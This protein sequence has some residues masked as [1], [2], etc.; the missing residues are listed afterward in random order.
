[1]RIEYRSGTIGVNAN[2]DETTAEI[3]AVQDRYSLGKDFQLPTYD[4]IVDAIDSL[5]DKMN[6]LL[7]ASACPSISAYSLSAA[8]GSPRAIFTVSALWPLWLPATA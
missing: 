6:L 4:V 5:T 3:I 2:K 1:M 7:E 8:A